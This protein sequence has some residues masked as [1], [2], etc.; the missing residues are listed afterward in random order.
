MTFSYTSLI[1]T[2]N[3]GRATL[4]LAPMAGVTDRVFRDISRA[5]GAD[6]AVSEMVASKKELWQSAKSSSRHA[7]ESEESPRIVQLLGTDPEELSEAAKWQQ[8]KGAQ[9]IDLNM[10]C[11]AKKVCDVAAGSALLAYPERVQAI[12]ET[13]QKSVD[14]PVTVK[15]RTGISPENKNALE[16]A[17]LAEACGLSAITIHGR[18]RADK[19][20]GKAEYDTIR[21]VKSSVSI[22]VIANGD[23]CTPE[24]ADFVLKY[25]ACDGIMIGRAAQGNPWLFKQISHYLDTQTLLE[26]PSPAEIEAVVMQHLNGLYQLY[27]EIQGHRI[28]RKHIGWYSQH[29][30]NGTE[31]RKQFNQLSSAQAQLELVKEF[32]KP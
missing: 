10:G 22:P 5:L 8:D 19:F 31:L 15:I 23:I 1:G 2:Q 28:A 12:F 16:I 25:T 24:D 26:K 9:V 13:V 27:G 29:L 20:N 6:Y 30:T 21:K 14:L 32:F 17:K 4:A 7:D 11:P 18:T 3:T